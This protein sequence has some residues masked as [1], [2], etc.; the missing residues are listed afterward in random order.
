M[1]IMSGVRTCIVVWYSGRGKQSGGGGGD[2]DR[3]R[4]GYPGYD[5]RS[6]AVPV[7]A[8]GKK[9]KTQWYRTAH[10]PG[11]RGPKA[12]TDSGWLKVKEA[13]MDDVGEQATRA[14]TELRPITIA[15]KSSC[16]SVERSFPLDCTRPTD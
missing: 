7:L 9:V 15:W 1:E 2:V 6:A 11:D 10:E 8:A 5:L 4:M 16:V 13:G 12:R 3:T 14:R